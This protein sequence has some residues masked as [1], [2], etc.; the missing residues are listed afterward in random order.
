[1]MF[2]NSELLTISMTLFKQL[3]PRLNFKLYLFPYVLMY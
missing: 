1:M 2:V 3:L